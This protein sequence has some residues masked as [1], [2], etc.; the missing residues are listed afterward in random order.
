MNSRHKL[1]LGIKFTLCKSWTASIRLLFFHFLLAIFKERQLGRISQTAI[2]CYPAVIA[3]Q[4]GQ[5]QL[6]PRMAFKAP[7]LRQLLRIHHLLNPH[8]VLGQ[9]SCFIGADHID[10]P[11]GFDSRKSPDDRVYPNHTGH[12]QSKDDGYHCRESFRNYRDRKCDRRYEHL[13][14]IPFLEDSRREQ[15]PAHPNCQHT[16]KH[17]QLSQPLL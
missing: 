4:K 5:L 12:R 8:P 10:C 1:P 17:P 9:C 3:K 6:H 7:S 15:K 16:E 14:R 11:Q 13:R 2:F